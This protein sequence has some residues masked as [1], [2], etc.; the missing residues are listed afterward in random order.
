MRSLRPGMLKPVIMRCPDG[1]FRRVIFGIGPYV[2]DYPEQALVACIVQG[3]CPT[4]IQHRTEL[5]NEVLDGVRCREHTAELLQHFD[6]G[7]LWD[8]YGIDANVIVSTICFRH[9]MHHI[10]FH[11][12]SHSQATSH[13]PIFTS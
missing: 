9:K 1:H 5:G 6:S 11:H 3:W 2:A 12:S 7:T 10:D 8:D 13:V 4:C